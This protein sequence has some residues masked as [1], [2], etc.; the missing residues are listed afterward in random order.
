MRKLLLPIQGD[1]IAPR[2]DLATEIVVVRFEEGK[3]AGEPRNFIM[4]SPSDEE[5]CQMIVELNITD[6]VC[7]GI[8]ELHYNFLIWKKV[9]VIDGIIADWHTALDKAVVDGLQP[10]TLLKP[11][12][13]HLNL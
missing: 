5:L 4:D 12:K 11:Q 2:F 10:E 13:Q 6:V 9:N 1:F 7:G 3:V 8:E